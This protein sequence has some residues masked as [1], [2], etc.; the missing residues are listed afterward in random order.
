M[1]IKSHEIQPS[2][3]G[4]LIFMNGALLLSGETNPLGFVR[5]FFVAQSQQGNLYSNILFNFLLII[6]KF[7][8]CFS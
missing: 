6:L 5:V 8:Y 3:N 7:F 4:I 1:E 2:N